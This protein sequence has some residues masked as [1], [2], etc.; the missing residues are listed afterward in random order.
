MGRTPGSVAMKLTNLASLDAQIT[1]N[2]RKSLASTSRLDRAVW[3]ELQ[4][5]WDVVA[6]QAASS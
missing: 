6:L 1:A 4:S 2:G 5:H 3:S